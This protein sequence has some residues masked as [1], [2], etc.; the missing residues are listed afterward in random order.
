MRYTMIM[1]REDG[2]SFHLEEQGGNLGERRHRV[3][4]LLR[5][6]SQATADLAAEFDRHDRSAP[7]RT[8]RGIRRRHKRVLAVPEHVTDLDVAA[9][10]RALR[11]AGL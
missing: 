6:V 10:R 11:R 1:E 9:A 4:E 8:R 3:A 7:P 5:V 2:C